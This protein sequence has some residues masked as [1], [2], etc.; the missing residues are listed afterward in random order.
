MMYMMTQYYE[1]LFNRVEDADNPR[2]RSYQKLLNK[3]YCREF[4]YR[5]ARDSN[6]A[7]DGVALRYEFARLYNY[8]YSDAERYITGQCRMLEMMIAL[9]AR[10]EREQSGHDDAYIWFW[11]MIESLGLDGMNDID[12]DEGFV[13]TVLNRFME[14]SYK[15]NGEGSLF[16]LRHTTRDMRKTELW[17]QMCLYL[18]ELFL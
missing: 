7:A 4:S 12:Y 16:T 13:D 6:R 2:I 14:G 5:I 1:W 8:S 18:D 11:T 3:L 17:Y 10:C 9:A 15:R